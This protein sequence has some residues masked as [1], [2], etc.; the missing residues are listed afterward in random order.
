MMR[1]RPAVIVLILSG[2]T[3]IATPLAIAVAGS[4]TVPVTSVGERHATIAAALEGTADPRAPLS[5]PWPDGAAA[6]GVSI[7]QAERA[8]AVYAPALIQ[9]PALDVT[10]P[11]MP[12]GL[13]AAQAIQ[14]PEDIGSVGWYSLGVAPGSRV[15]SAVIVGHRDGRVAGHGALYDLA[16]L[17]P[18]NRILVVDTAGRELRFAVVA[19]EVVAKSLLP[20]DDLFAVDGPARLTLITCGGTYDRDRGGYQANVIVTAVPAR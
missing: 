18:G 14:I 3:L 15:G 10:A 4:P 7:A 1:P 8:A 12:V 16:R 6:P 5:V 13:D 19:R 2:M 17:E 20:A 11:V 9:I